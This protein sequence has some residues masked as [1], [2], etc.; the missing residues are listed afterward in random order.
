MAFWGRRARRLLPALYALLLTVSISAVTFAKDVEDGL[1]GDVLAALAYVSNWWLI[2]DDDSYFDTFGR[3]P[4][5][6]HLW[7]LA[8]EEQFYIIFPILMAVLFTARRARPPIASVAT[9]G[10]VASTVLMAVLYDPANP[11]RVYYGTDTRAAGLFIGVALAAV[12]PLGEIRS[13]LGR[14]QRSTVNALG[15]GSLA[16]LVLFMLLLGEDS[17]FLFQGGGFLFASML[18]AVAVAVAVHPASRL[19]EALAWTPLLWIGTR[20]Y[21]LYLWHWPVL[22]LTSPESGD[23]RAGLSLVFQL[24]IIAV[25]AE[26]SWRYIEK[27]FR[28][29]QV[30]RWWEARSTVGHRRLLAAA[31]VALLFLGGALF[32]GREAEVPSLL[33]NGPTRVTP[34]LPPVSAPRT[35]R[36]PTTRPG[37]GPTTT[38]ALPPLGPMLAIG[39]SVMLGA[40]DALTFASGGSIAVDAAVSRQVDEG[41]DIL[42]GYLDRG[43]LDRFEGV[44]IHLG[45]NGP[46]TA[47][48]ADRLVDLVKDVDQVVV[49]NTRV[50]QPWEGESNATVSSLRGV[51]H[52]AIADWYSVS[53]DGN[54]LDGDGVHPTPEGAAFYA[55]TIVEAARS[56]R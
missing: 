53:A 13:D 47:D 12:W 16:G 41:L 29:G 56:I 21:A 7:S 17:T 30:H 50:P 23:L 45:T 14:R 3:P 18:A 20:S 25:L 36:P 4:L 8:V 26:L 43:D 44:I 40:R 51:E 46:F 54:I 10:A 48:Q 38:T 32:V 27:P 52:L 22:V 39:D 24:A 42:Q 19:S 34:D 35:T 6:R 2:V 28:T 5:L 31:G 11:S 55:R 9:A 15:W 37:G 49:V 1:F 33:A